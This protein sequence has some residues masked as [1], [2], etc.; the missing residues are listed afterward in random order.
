MDKVTSGFP[1]SIGTA[2]A[3]ETILPMTKEPYDKNRVIPPKPDMAIYDRTLISLRT[4]LRNIIQAY[5][6]NHPKL[7]KPDFL[8]TEMLVEMD[9]INNLFTNNNLI[10]PSYYYSDYALNTN[11]IF[12]L[13]TNDKIK[14]DNYLI[15]EILNKINRKLFYSFKLDIETGFKSILML[16]HIPFDL[17]SYNKY[18][19]LD[20]LESHTG[21]I[22]DRRKWYT[23]YYQL[24]KEDMSI[25]PF[26]A[27]LLSIMGDKY[28]IQPKSL[29]L[30][31]EVYEVAMEKKWNSLTNEASVIRDLKGKKIK[32]NTVSQ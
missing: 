30:R 27:T 16:S 13:K 2:L 9:Y 7:R 21:I 8:K 19:R 28:L 10:S 14:Y 3:L 5:P 18:I 11:N 15:K 32:W 4:L 17:L 20:L 6:N 1:L 24:P 25:L 22:K 31:R 26:N 29:I 23:K 12:N